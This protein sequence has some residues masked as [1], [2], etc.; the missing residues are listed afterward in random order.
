MVSFSVIV[1]FGC[2]RSQDEATALP[3]GEV[4]VRGV[5][6]PA[7]LS[8]VR[9]GSFRLSQEGKDA[10]Y[11]ESPT[12]PLPRFIGR[13]YLFRGL[14]EVNSDRSALPVLVVREVRGDDVSSPF[15]SSSLSSSLPPLS[16]SGSGIPCGGDGG[17]LCPAGEYCAVEMRE[18]NIGRCRRVGS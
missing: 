12:V 17:V 8:S 1:L 7:D 3:R 15:S 4:W 2:V 9:R 18:T 6:H 5:L 16:H 10:Y 11:V 14:M 13:E